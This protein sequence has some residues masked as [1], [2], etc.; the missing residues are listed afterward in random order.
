MIFVKL[1]VL[2]PSSPDLVPNAYVS[3]FSSY[4]ETELADLRFHYYAE[5]QAGKSMVKI[6]W[7]RRRGDFMT[8]EFIIIVAKNTHTRC[9]YIVYNIS[10]K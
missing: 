2:Y 9:I 7:R 5:L 8:T 3:P 6:T 1:F 10:I 4:K